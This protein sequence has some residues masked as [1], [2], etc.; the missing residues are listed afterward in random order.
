MKEDDMTEDEIL[1][2][3]LVQTAPERI[4]LQ[5]GDDPDGYNMEWP[6][7][8]ASNGDVTWCDRSVMKVEVPYVRADLLEK[9]ETEIERLDAGLH[10][11]WYNG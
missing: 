4:Y 3:T 2:S 1:N 11:E 9:A 6:E 7:E 5:V 10:G 8:A